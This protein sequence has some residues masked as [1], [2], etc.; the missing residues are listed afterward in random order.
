MPRQDIHIGV[1]RKWCVS[2]GVLT[3]ISMSR[4]EAEMRLAA[5]TS[6]LMSDFTDEAFTKDSLRYVA[7][8]CVKGF[9]TYPELHNHLRAWWRETRPQPPALPPPQ[10][11]R[12]RDEPTPEEIAHVERVVA[13]LLGEFRA[14]AQWERDDRRPSPSYLTP[15]QLDI[16][17]PLRGGR[18]RVL[19]EFVK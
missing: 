5:F 11:I 18:K 16:V 17:N 2:L 13:E 19:T 10:P 8:A 9:P 14:R 6:M 4:E 12:Q 15:A 7:K 3:A 1:V